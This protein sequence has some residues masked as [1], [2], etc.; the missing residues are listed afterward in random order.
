M[1]RSPHH[2]SRHRRLRR[3]HHRLPSEHDR[4]LNC[5]VLRRRIQCH[6]FSSCE[7]RQAVTIEIR[8]TTELLFKETTPEGERLIWQVPSAFKGEL[9]IAARQI[10]PSGIVRRGRIAK[11]IR[12]ASAE[13]EVEGIWDRYRSYAYRY[14]DGLASNDVRTILQDKQGAIWFGTQGGV[15]RF[16]G[17]ISPRPVPIRDR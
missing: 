8:D 5:R 16:D 13:R 15:S 9:Q 10:D 3:L 7:S 1:H 6:R 14:V 4:G 11:R 2:R 17:T 12:I